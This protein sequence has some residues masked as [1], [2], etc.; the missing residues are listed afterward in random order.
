MI[1]REMAF[2]PKIVLKSSI[3]L[4]VGETPEIASSRF[5]ILSSKPASVL[6]RSKMTYFTFQ[7]SVKQT[8]I[9]TSMNSS[10]MRTTRSLTASH[11]IREGGVSL[12]GVCPRGCLP[13]GCVSQHGMGQTS[14]PVN[15]MTDKQV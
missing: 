2:R 13:R 15:W 5:A 4:K 8:C 11:I 10:R 1:T 3:Q 9:I 12:G 7:S 6:K 14:P